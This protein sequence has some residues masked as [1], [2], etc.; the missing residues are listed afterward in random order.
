MGVQKELWQNSIE[1]E[2]F[3]SNEFLKY[4]KNADEYVI[5]GA[6]VHIPQSGGPTG[7]QRN[8][9]TFPAAVVTRTD[10]EVL[11][12]LDEYTTNPT[13]IPYAD[14]VELSYDKRQ[15]VVR[16]NTEEMM[17]LI[18][19]TMLHRWA[20]GLPTSLII[21]ATGAG[22]VSTVPGTTGNRKIITEA[23]LRKAQTLMNLQNV[24]K[25]NRYAILDSNQIDQLFSNNDVKKYTQQ[26]LDLPD[27]AIAKLSGFNIIER[28]SALILGNDDNSKL[29]EAAIAA[30]DDGAGIFFQMNAVERAIGDIKFFDNKDRAEYYADIFSHLVRANGRRRR[31]D[32]KGVIILRNVVSA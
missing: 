14:T 18:G 8:R 17:E 16:E 31:L 20:D 3:A 13:R 2:L 9:T 22:S 11:Y 15:S 1:E 12:P 27:G 10:T 30:D 24:A 25:K 28:S 6:I 32:N 29:P 21:A 5:G 19:S 23:D 26:Y 4:A 7:V